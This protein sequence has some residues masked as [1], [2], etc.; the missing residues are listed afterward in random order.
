ML[1]R[2]VDIQRNK[3]AKCFEWS[4]RLG[5]TLFKNVCFPFKLAVFVRMTCLGLVAGAVPEDDGVDGGWTTGIH[6]HGIDA[7]D[8]AG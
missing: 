7:S 6:Q 3:S 4:C 1:P 2:G 5:A 8:G